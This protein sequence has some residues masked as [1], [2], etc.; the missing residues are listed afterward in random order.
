MILLIDL[1]QL[2]VLQV[3]CDPFVELGQQFQLV[4]LYPDRE[5]ENADRDL[6]LEC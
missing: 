3:G 5:V 6:R 2:A 1:V 4:L